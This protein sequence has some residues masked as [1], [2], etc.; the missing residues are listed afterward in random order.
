MAMN[1][2]CFGNLWVLP[3]S[4]DN[5]DLDKEGVPYKIYEDFK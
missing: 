1:L 3:Y 2:H 5:E 4:Y